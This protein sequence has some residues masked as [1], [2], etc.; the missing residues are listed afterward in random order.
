MYRPR[1]APRDAPLT[2]RSCCSVDEGLVVAAR[3]APQTRTRW[4]PGGDAHAWNHRQ[5]DAGWHLFR[6]GDRDRRG[7]S[8]LR[9]SERPDGLVAVRGCDRN[10]DS[11]A[12]PVD[13][14]LVVE[15]DR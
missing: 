13:V 12:G 6:T 2:G 8:R 11:G 7:S 14:P 9:L 3:L 15:R 5:H 1:V 4:K 10:A